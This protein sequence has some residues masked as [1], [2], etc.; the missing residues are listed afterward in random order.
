MG[1]NHHSLAGGEKDFGRHVKR[2]ATSTVFLWGEGKKNHT[3]GEKPLV[4]GL[5]HPLMKKRR[6]AADLIFQTALNFRG[7]RCRPHKGGLFLMK[8]SGRRVYRQDKKKITFPADSL[9][10]ITAIGEI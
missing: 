10:K 1:D 6:E 9:V 2:V 4:T 5:P 7:G 3:H 8:W